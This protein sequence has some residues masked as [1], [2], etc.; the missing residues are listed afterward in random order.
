MLQK[1][2]VSL[3]ICLSFSWL[4]NLGG[5]NSVHITFL[6]SFVTGRRWFRKELF[7]G[8]IFRYFST[9]SLVYL[10]IFVGLQIV[11]SPTGRLWVWPHLLC[12]FAITVTAAIE[13]A[14][15]HSMRSRQRCRSLPPFFIHPLQSWL[16]LLL[17]QVDVFQWCGTFT[18][19]NLYL[20][21]SHC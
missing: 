19:D 10:P 9:I 12:R 5:R 3:E 6:F 14:V 13:L 1:L 18:S 4:R 11:F 7:L 16:G 20:V 15:D 2:L 17:D 8:W 21:E